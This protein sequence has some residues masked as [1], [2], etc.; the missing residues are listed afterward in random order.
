[1]FLICCYCC[2]TF[3]YT[4][5]CIEFY[6]KTSK[7]GENVFPDCSQSRDPNVMPSGLKIRFDAAC[8]R[9]IRG[10]SALDSINR[11]LRQF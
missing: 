3:W 9:R 4:D 2:V 6:F 10:K 7:Q 5:W 11:S 8:F 1:M